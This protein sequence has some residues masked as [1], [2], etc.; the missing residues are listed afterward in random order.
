MSSAD[1]VQTERLWA[2]VD[3][4]DVGFDG[5]FEFIGRAMDAEADLFI[6]EI[7]EEALNLTDPGG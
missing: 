1:F 3:G 7:F 5:G 4:F 6:R 2:G